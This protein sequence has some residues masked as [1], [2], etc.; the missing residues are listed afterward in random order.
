MNVKMIDCVGYI[1]EGAM[2]LRENDSERMVMTPWSK[3]PLPFEVAAE[4][5]TKKVIELHSTIGIM[6]TSDGTFGE[7]EREHIEESENRVIEDLK[8]SKKPFVIVLNSATPDDDK[9]IE[10]AMELEARHGVPVILVNCLELDQNDIEGILE[11]SLFEFPVTEMEID[12]PD[13]LLALDDNEVRGNIESEISKLAKS[14]TSISSLSSAIG[15]LSKNDNIKSDYALKT[16][17]GN[18]KTKIKIELCDELFITDI[19]LDEDVARVAFNA[20]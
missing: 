6:L 14:T 4:T 16:E 20:F 2:G 9:A 8:K 10:L 18:G 12:M 17:L 1:V 7:L 15:A 5:G 11:L 3:S 19:A 13:W